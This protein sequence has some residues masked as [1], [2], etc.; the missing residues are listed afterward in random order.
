MIESFNKKCLFRKITFMYVSYKELKNFKIS[1]SSKHTSYLC[2]IQRANELQAHFQVNISFKQPELFK[3][4][5]E[6]FET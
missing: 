3:F 1:E 4:G 2:E 5:V 6:T